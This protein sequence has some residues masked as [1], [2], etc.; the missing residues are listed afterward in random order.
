MIQC[1]DC[2]LTSKP[3]YIKTTLRLISAAGLYHMFD[4]LVGVEFQLFQTTSL[5]DSIF[6]FL[7]VVFIGR[8]RSKNIIMPNIVESR[9]GRKKL[10]C[11][12]THDVQV[13]C[14]S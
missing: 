6:I 4:W 1:L 2:L 8:L 10:R 11:R 13:V 9:T 5:D 14:N 3:L 7:R 12:H